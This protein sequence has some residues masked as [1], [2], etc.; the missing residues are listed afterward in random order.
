MRKS[1]SESIVF[2]NGKFILAQK[3]KLLVCKPGF[4]YGWGLFETMRSYNNRIL[5]LKEHLNRIK[6]ASRAIKMAFPYALS[7]LKEIIEK[8]VGLNSFKDAYVRLT[9]WKSDSKTD[10][11]VVARKY[12]PY[13]SRKY[14]QGFWACASQF[15]QNENYFLAQFK[16]TNYLLYQ[17]A[18]LE[19]KDKGFDEA[20]MLNSRG[21]LCEASRSNLFFVK[22]KEIFTPDLECG[23]LAGIT[24]KVIFD[25]AKKYHLGIYAGKFTLQDLYTADEAFLTNSLLGIMP[26]AGIERHRI[27]KGAVH[28]KLTRFL[29]RRYLDLL[30]NGT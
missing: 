17:L 14:K 16:T 29:L 13:T 25:L 27:A 10:I 6:Q 11:L 18:Y 26:L 12:Q 7:D 22:N 9:A 28:F 4:L 21:Y 2:L 30:K 20:I 3:A 8:T 23:C 15:K 24:R 5:Y 1:K 19:A